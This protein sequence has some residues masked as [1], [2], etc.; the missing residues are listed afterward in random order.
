MDINESA[1]KYLARLRAKWDAA[2]QLPNDEV[3]GPYVKTAAITLGVV[4]TLCNPL[5]VAGAITIWEVNKHVRHSD[6]NETKRK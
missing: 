2:K 5:L 4:T 1:D 3:L 6:G